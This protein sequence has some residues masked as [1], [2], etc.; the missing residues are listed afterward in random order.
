MSPVGAIVAGVAT[1]LFG[2]IDKLF[3]SDDERAQAKLKLIALEQ[4]GEL[5]QL[6]VQ[7]SAILAEAQSD[8]KWTSRARPSFLYVMYAVIGLCFLAGIM[9]VW[10][11]GEMQQ[12]AQNVRYMLAAIPE[13]MWW[14]F[15]VGYTG[16]TAGRSVDKFVRGWQS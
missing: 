3:T 15:G 14:V 11:P 9:G 4:A 2:L 12:V 1:P 6:R 16:Y 8:D 5:E 10:W 7:L 13:P